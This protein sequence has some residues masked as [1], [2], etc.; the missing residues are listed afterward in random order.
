MNRPI[1]EITLIMNLGYGETNSKKTRK[2]NQ[3]LTEG[4]GL[5]H[6]VKDKDNIVKRD[7]TKTGLGTTLCR[8]QDDGNTKQIALGSIYLNETKTKYPIDVLELLAVLW[9]LEKLRFYLYGKK[10]IFTQIIKH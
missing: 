5:G 8:K 3:M 10:Y 7:A 6:Y 1:Q 2:I 9:E 4:S